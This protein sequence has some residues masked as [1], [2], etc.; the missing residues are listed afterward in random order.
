M[1]NNAQMTDVTI[2]MIEEHVETGL[3][4]LLGSYR[5][6][7]IPGGEQ[8]DRLGDRFSLMP[9]RSLPEFDHE[10]AKAYEA[11]DQYNLSRQT[12]AMVC[13]NLLPYNLRAINELIGYSNPN[14][15]QVLGAGTVNCSHLNESRQVI[16]FERPQ[17]ARLSELIKIGGRMHEHKVID[18]VLQPACKALNAMADKNIPHGNIHPGSFYLSDTALLGEGISMPAGS[19]SHYL[20]KPI[21]RL[22][23][24]PLG[25]GDASD[26]TDVYAL[27][28]LAFELM[29]G[30]EKIKAMP[31]DEFIRGA[32]KMGTYHAFTNNR[33]FS[34]A[35]QDLFRGVFN[36]NVADRWGLEEFTQWIG[37]KRFNVIAPS[38]PK[39]AVRPLV[40]AGESFFSRRLLA[41][42]LHRHW[43]DSLKEV[44]NL[45]LDRWCETSLHRPELAENIERALRSGSDRN[46][47][48]W[49]L[50]EML[51]KI[52]SILDPVG[53]IRTLTMSIR[54]DAIGITLAD[55]MRQR[56]AELSTLL[57]LIE[58][59][60]TTFWL[61]QDDGHKSPDMSVVMWK[62]QRA[63]QYMRN[64]SFG[65]GLERVLYEM[66]TSLPCQSPLLMQYHVT[67]AVDALKTLD[68][69]A[70]SL[71]PD[72][73]FTDRHLA[74][75]IAAKIDMG[76]EMNLND[77][78]N[79]PALAM[80]QEL[81][82]L[83]I[84]AKAQH[85]QSKLVLVGLSTW[86]AMRV[87]KMV[88]EVHNRIIR[89]R[90]KL[91]LKKIASS[92]NLAEVL[93]AIINRDMVTRDLDGFSEALAMHSLGQ[94]KILRLENEDVI[95]F[96]ARDMGGRIATNIC[97]TIMLIVAYIKLAEIVGL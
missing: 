74:A 56:G 42:S 87:E 88:D 49:Q 81:V 33:D 51:S 24:D 76:K 68:A 58:S 28:I 71:A 55:M 26:K 90:L 70:A 35:L 95:V 31:R 18:T 29:F 47:T 50:N 85:K 44:Q 30:L 91:Q 73:A 75:F 46:A 48:D 4:D 12:Y 23:C 93:G 17:G 66:N 61:E 36:D 63:R 1:A 82:V 89:K 97:Y 92:G 65:F 11:Q 59:N 21:E 60:M 3:S 32:L 14:M 39:E 34:D 25:Y 6:T 5:S 94:E 80:N 19:Q 72:T 16:F 27:T 69:L 7:Y 54:P 13:D 57:G 20:Y 15:V 37:G 78:H 10:Y 45:K 22:I 8:K 53:P 67:T 41:N 86:A 77:L 84:L 83:R 52:I 43:R 2:P 62:L 79:V 64:K 9:S 38:P 96:K 40:F